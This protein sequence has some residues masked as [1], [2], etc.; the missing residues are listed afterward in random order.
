M[1]DPYPSVA[2]IQAAVIAAF[3]VSQLDLMS[4]RAGRLI[5]RPRQVGYWLARHCTPMSLPEIGRAF[6]RRDHTTILHGIAVVDG[7]IARNQ[8]VGGVALRLRAQLAG[9]TA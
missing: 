2:A 8:S 3:G 5:A 1:S 6:G 9:E 4:R 7:L